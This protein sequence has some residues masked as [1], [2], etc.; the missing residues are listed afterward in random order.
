[1]SPNVQSMATFFLS[2]YK[3]LPFL[4][5]L[6]LSLSYRKK[7]SSPARNGRTRHEFVYATESSHSVRAGVSGKI[8]QLPAV[9]NVTILA[10]RQKTQKWGKYSTVLVKGMLS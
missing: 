9:L 3:C 5:R 10:R 8:V 6:L 1:M 2:R 7:E 4:E